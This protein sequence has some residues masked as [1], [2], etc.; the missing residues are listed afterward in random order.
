[1]AVPLALLEYVYEA[2][3]GSEILAHNGYL[4]GD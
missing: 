1:M 2:F 3:I 4:F